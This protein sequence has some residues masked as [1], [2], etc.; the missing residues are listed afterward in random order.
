M[1][2]KLKEIV[3]TLTLSNFTKPLL[4][5][6]AENQREMPWRSDP[7]PYHVLLSEIMLQQTR[8]E[9]VRDYY[10]RFLKMFPTVES[11][12]SADE[13]TLLK[14]WEGLGYYSR[15]RNLHAAARMIAENGFPDSFDSLLALPGV[16]RYTA[17]AVSSIAFGRREPCVDGNVLRVLTRFCADAR[18]VDHPS[19]RLWAEEQVRAVLPQERPGDLNQAVMEL[20][21]LVCIP[22]SPQCDRCPLV[23]D[24]AGFQQGIAARLPVR[25]EKRPRKTEEITVFLLLCGERVAL[26]R[27]SEKGVL[28]GMW[29]YPNVS[30]SLDQEQ[31]KVWLFSHGEEEP[32]LY[33]LEH[34]RHT[35][36]HLEWDLSGYAAR[37][38]EPLPG[39]VWIAYDDLLQNYPI[40]SAFRV[41][42][43]ELARIMRERA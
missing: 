31:A 1:T 4:A 25:A 5:W 43:K 29:E 34:G 21:A 26:R 3:S 23:A 17:G 14:Q 2:G 27:R 38:Q 8:V 40:P 12:A 35:F 6:F 28:A 20:G 33:P 24:C 15:A 32:D 42:S 9:T 11:L 7:T 36:T 41:Y 18:C 16:G 37:V 19:A 39:Y 22:G 10:L 30:G 13:Q